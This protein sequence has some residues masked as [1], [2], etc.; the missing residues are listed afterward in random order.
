MIV[1]VYVWKISN[2]LEVIEARHVW[3]SHETVFTLH[4][5]YNDNR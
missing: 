3:V 5:I 4:I 1:S 2:Q